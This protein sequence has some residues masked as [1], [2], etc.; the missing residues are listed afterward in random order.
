MGGMS[1]RPLGAFIATVWLDLLGFYVT[2]QYN[3]K[4]M[5]WDYLGLG[6]SGRGGATPSHSYGGIMS[7][8]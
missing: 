5:V 1:A 4:G 7:V 8:S 6:P 2:V 3:Y